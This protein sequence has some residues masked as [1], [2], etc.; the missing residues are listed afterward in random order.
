MWIEK[1]TY[2]VLS[3]EKTRHFCSN[4]H[5]SLEDRLM[6]GRMRELVTSNDTVQK[7]HAFKTIMVNVNKGGI[8]IIFHSHHYESLHWVHPLGIIVN[9]IYFDK[10]V[11]I[12][13]L[14]ECMVW[15][16]KSN[17]GIKES[18]PWVSKYLNFSQTV[19]F[20]GYVKVRDCLYTQVLFQVNTMILNHIDTRAIFPT[21][22]GSCMI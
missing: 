5:A 19:M 18:T 3:K 12:Q 8:N 10:E 22:E 11:E 16:F 20:G 1:R 9:T 7:E 6:I 2:C 21:Y 4:F 17:N 14:G 15:V 13:W